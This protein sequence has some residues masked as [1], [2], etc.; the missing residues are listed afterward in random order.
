ML[1]PLT[2][3]EPI[4]GVN[5][6]SAPGGTIAL[7]PNDQMAFGLPAGFNGKGT[8][9]VTNQG[10]QLHEAAFYKLADGKTQGDVLTFFQAGVPGP[11]PI[12]GAGGVSALAPGSTV[13]TTLNL[14]PG[15]YVL[16][17]FLPDVLNG[18]VPHYQEGMISTVNI[19]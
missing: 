5:L 15:S 6:P 2:V 7:G 12:T 11:P 1:A 13:T 16:M 14:G 4:G 8:Y 18:G 9:D 3:D 10:T 17:C 19:S